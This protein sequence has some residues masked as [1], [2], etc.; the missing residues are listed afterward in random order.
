MRKKSKLEIFLE[1]NT[2]E[3]YLS[4]IINCGDNDNCWCDSGKK[5]KDCH[6]LLKGKDVFLGRADFLLSK[7]LTKKICLHPDDDQCNGKIIDAHSIQNSKS[8]ESISENGHVYRFVINSKEVDDWYKYRTIFPQKLG[9]AKTSVFKGFC[10]FH[11]R[12]LFKEID[13]CPIIPTKKQSTLL[14]IRSFAREIY[15]KSMVSGMDEIYKE[16]QVSDDPYLLALSQDGLKSFMEGNKYGKDDLI[17]HYTNFF[18]IYKYSEYE[19]LNRLIIK[20]DKIPE[21]MCSA[22]F[23]PEYDLNG[24]K[25]Q[26][27]IKDDFIEYLSFEV[28]VE[29]NIGIIHF[30]WYDNFQHCSS[31]VNSILEQEDISNTIIKMIFQFSEN[32]AFKISWFDN[33]SVLRKKG[34]MN[35]MMLNIV[36]LIEEENDKYILNDNKKYVDWTIKEIIK[37]Y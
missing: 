37:E 13:I 12:E 35:L 26:D 5:Y 22:C 15:T 32:H 18:H 17:G 2:P 20:V 24:N 28:F 14:S 31:F 36:S 9:K 3:K 4:K 11:D 29:N 19:R 7:L 8:L 16:S 34:L 27:Y 23:A 10:S 6:K 30:C 33:L 1:E 25:L 21:V